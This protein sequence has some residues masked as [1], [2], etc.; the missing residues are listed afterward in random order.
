MSPEIEMPGHSQAAI[1]AY[2]SLSCTGQ[3]VEVANEWGVFKEVYCAGNEHTFEF[4]E[5]VLQEVFT[6]F[7]SQYVHIGGDECPKYRWKNC[8]KCQRRMQDENI[9]DEAAL[10]SY[11]IKRIAV[12]L[13]KHQKKL[14]GWDEILEG[15]LAKNAIV[16]SWRGMQG[17][18]QAALSKQYSI[19]SPTSHAYF[20][21]DLQ[22]IDLEKVYQFDP[23]PKG[24]TADQKT[25]YFRWRMQ[26]VDR[27]SPRR[28]HTRC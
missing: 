3:K 6:L 10:Q 28:T 11:F 27:T 18:K 17:A 14:I 23:I 16:Q 13:D 4:L 8:S 12:F 9:E 20:D 7:P 22:A 1:A 2:P 15:G 19:A 25:I 24:L 26:Y 5:T 21:Y